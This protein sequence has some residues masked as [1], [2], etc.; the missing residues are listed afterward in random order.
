MNS[1][2]MGRFYPHFAYPLG[3][4]H[5]DNTHWIAFD[6]IKEHDV[7]PAIENISDSEHRADFEAF[8]CSI[9]DQLVTGLEIGECRLE[10]KMIS[11][12]PRPS[13]GYSQQ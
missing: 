12:K 1:P 6:R 3:D 4:E 7:Q 10:G 8:V 9:R 11:E 13:S 5:D 2:K